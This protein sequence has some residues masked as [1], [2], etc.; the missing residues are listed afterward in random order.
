MRTQMIITLSLAAIAMPGCIANE[1]RDGLNLANENM[2]NINE[3]INRVELQLSNIQE[4][5]LAELQIKLEKISTIDQSIAD[6]N[7]DLDGVQISLTR[8]DEHLASLRKTLQNI[9]STIPFLSLAD[10][11]E[12]TDVP[13][14]G[15]DG[16]PIAPDDAASEQQDTNK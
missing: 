10:D 13:E 7:E 11:E 1:I 6:V 9:D 15:P 4:T 2:V 14:I 8:L 16:N 3:S 12:V 5:Q